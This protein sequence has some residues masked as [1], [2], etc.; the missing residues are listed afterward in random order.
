MTTDRILDRV[1]AANSAPTVTIDNQELFARIVASPGDPRLGE[2]KRRDRP[3][4]GHPLAV[5]GTCAALAACGTGA[6]KLGLIPDMGVFAHDTPT[7]LFKANPAGLD[8][9]VSHQVV[10]LRTVHRVASATVP[11][12]GTYEYWMALSRKG[13]LCSA[14]RAP[15]GTWADTSQQPSKFGISGPVP[16]CGWTW[17]FHGYA[18]YPSSVRSPDGRWWRLI[19]GYGPSVGHPVA[20]R[21]RFSGVS[22][23]IGDGRYFI[24]ALPFCGERGVERCTANM[25]LNPPTFQFETLDASGRVLTIGAPDQ[26]H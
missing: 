8:P 11:A 4:R 7:Q 15:D 25:N 9:N 24:I 3:F 14:I 10:N 13:W 16:G 23:P 17:P 26:G 2:A 12:L 21:D 18:Y 1:R 20:V 19:W 6:A 22:A 5:F